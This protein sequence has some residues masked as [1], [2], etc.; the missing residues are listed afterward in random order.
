MEVQNPLFYRRAENE[1]AGALNE[2][3][4]TK[5]QLRECL[6]KE[7]QF[8]ISSSSTGRKI[9]NHLMDT[10]DAERWKYV[11][12]LRYLEYYY[13]NRHKNPAY[14]FMNLIYAR[15]FNRLGYKL[16]I[17][18]NRG[19]FDEGLMIY[20]TSGIVV[21]GDAKVGKNCMLHGA[22]V[23]GNMGTDLKAPVIG[24]NVRLGAGAKVLGDV[25]I[26]DH[27]QIGAGAIVLHS[28]YE[29][30][31]LLVGIPARVH[32]RRNHQGSSESI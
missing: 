24:N 27:V 21:N 23:I 7:K 15:K 32:P 17:E 25:Y 13:N 4:V 31:A 30:G 5:K 19:V 20:H 8:Y 22:N 3:I 2:M 29:K 26:A 12:T 11:K 6:S 16:G 1:N 28:C 18:L 14:A 10:P 9:K